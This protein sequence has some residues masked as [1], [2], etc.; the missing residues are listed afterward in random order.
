MPFQDQP[1]GT[2]AKAHQTSSGR[3]AAAQANGT[4]AKAHQVISGHAPR[5]RPNGTRA[6]AAQVGGNPAF[7]HIGKP[8]TIPQRVVGAKNLLGQVLETVDGR[9][10]RVTGVD[11]LLPDT[12]ETYATKRCY[13]ALPDATA[14]ARR[15]DP[16][17]LQPRPRQPLPWEQPQAAPTA[18]IR[19][20]GLPYAP[21]PFDHKTYIGD[22]IDQ[23]GKH[24]NGVSAI[25]ES[26]GLT[27]ASKQKIHNSFYRGTQRFNRAVGRKVVPPSKVASRAAAVARTVTNPHVARFGSK[28]GTKIGYVGMG[29]SAAKIGYEYKT[30][31][32]D[33][34]T[35]VDGGML[36]VTAGGIIATVIAGGTAPV[37]VPIAGAVIL[38]YGVFDYAFD[39]NGSLDK[40]V[41]RDS[42]FKDVWKDMGMGR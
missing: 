13:G 21:A 19:P 37:W 5:Q 40:A 9:K 35:F 18:Y 25:M 30:N 7:E 20:Q 29:L 6:K 38:V 3:P 15:P 33:A 14:V 27:Y 32:Y 4:R 31:N 24:W 1:N 41:G 10:F 12:A 16:R 23:T 28:F 8:R 36:L 34:H 39:L 26:H 17:I 22:P 2:R 11:V 42:Q